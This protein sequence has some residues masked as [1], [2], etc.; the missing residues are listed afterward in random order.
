MGDALSYQFW[1]DAGF[2][3]LVSIIPPDATIAP[4]STI[5][6][7]SRGKAPGLPT[8]N[9]WV[10]YDW[11]KRTASRDNIAA[12]RGTGA[13]LGLKTEHFPA[14]DIDVLDGDLA[15]TIERITRDVLG[16]APCRVGRAPKRLLLY[17]TEVPMPKRRLAWEMNG[18]VQAVEVLGIGSQCV[19]EGI[20]PA[21]GKPYVWSP[22]HPVLFGAVALTPITAAQIDTLFEQVGAYLALFG[23]V[24]GESTESSTERQDV[25]QD[26][27]LGELEAVAQ[28]VRAIPNTEEMTRDDYLRMGYAIKAALPT[29]PDDAFELWC[30]WAE[31]W[32]GGVNEIATLEADWAR[33]KPPFAVG[34]QYLYDLAAKHGDTS[35]TESQFTFE[36]A[37]SPNSKSLD[38]DSGDAGETPAGA[39]PDDSAAMFSDAWLASRFITR[40][41]REVRYCPKLGGWMYWD[42]V[43][44]T[45][46]ELGLVGSWAARI[47]RESAIEAEA[48]ASTPAEARSIPRWCNSER[49]VQ[50]LLNYASRHQ[51]IVARVEDFDT[52]PWLLN[53]PTGILD[54][55]DGT[56]TENAPERM[57]TKCTL[58]GPS[59]EPPVRWLAFLEEVTQGDAAL[60]SY[61]KRLFGY[62]LTGVTEEEMLAFF[63][64][65][66]GNGKGTLLKTISKILGSYATTAAMETF[67][68]SEYDRHPADL[69]ALAGARL[70]V[71]QETQEGRAWDEA[72]IK[73]LTGSDPITA[74]FMRQ[75]FFTYQPQFKLVFAGN[76]RPN[77]LS[78]DAAMLRRF[79]LIPFNVQPKEVDTHLKDRLIHEY[80]SILGW[81]VEG[82][83]E[84]RLS[85]LSAPTAVLDSTHEYFR[86]ADPTGRWLEERCEFVTSARAL[87]NDLF[88]DY[89]NWCVSEGEE[90]HTQNAFA[91]ALKRRGLWAWR[92]PQ[93]RARGFAG[94]QLAAAPLLDART[95]MLLGEAAPVSATQ[96]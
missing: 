43:R 30:A 22:M 38:L 59:S 95:A 39:I 53:T 58:V 63:W 69:A 24:L 66:G 50:Q 62:A 56:R 61:L 71:A 33:M 73:T 57:M 88:T 68:A 31:R 64:G 87:S 7:K 2:E 42:G 4:N 9:G 51:A 52:D 25:A 12:W 17:R 65:T 32:A 80:A 14:V 34:A 13:G 90:S 75:D 96:H 27:L 49:A 18:A 81:M 89:R 6:E 11:I 15:A 86:D 92:D 78:P 29:S 85:H 46:D 41:R 91:R 5:Q 37:P 94:I 23:Y 45:V 74:R 16:D 55:R 3:S 72:K 48:H 40:H 70:V 93:S 35:R 28:A 8:T 44:W 77:L 47:G 1:Y 21:T 79:H 19:V 26:A 20:H 60:Q 84:W 36:N 54:L 83:Q 76:H 67:T 82:C 10:G